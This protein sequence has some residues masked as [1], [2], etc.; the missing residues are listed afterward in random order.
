MTETMTG[1]LEFFSETGTEGGWY[2]FMDTS[3]EFA[4]N[5]E[6]PCWDADE[7]SCP[8]RTIYGAENGPEYAGKRASDWHWKYEGL[9]SLNNGDRLKIWSK[10]KTEVVWEGEVDLRSVDSWGPDGG[11]LGLRVHQKSANVD[12]EQWL[13]WFAAG[14]P[15]E[16]TPAEEKVT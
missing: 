11:T 2:Q 8:T 3:P 1:I 4:H 10:D 9:R 7:S 16:L 15:A 6:Q 5:Y 13:R 14:L 12:E